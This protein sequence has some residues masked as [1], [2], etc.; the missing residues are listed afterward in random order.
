[1]PCSG[2]ASPPPC[3]TM[4]PLPSAQEDGEVLPLYQ[5]VS[6]SLAPRLVAVPPNLLS[7]KQVCCC[8]P[9]ARVRAWPAYGTAVA[10]RHTVLPV[11][12]AHDPRMITSSVSFLARHCWVLQAHDAR[13]AL[14]SC[15]LP[16]RAAP[17]AAVQTEAMSDLHVLHACRAPPPGMGPAAASCRPT[18]PPLALPLAAGAQPH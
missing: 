11:A 16:G 17:L 3:N 10:G 1:M 2:P 5:A 9:P 18:H 15:S 13:P 14:A 6:P 7:I 4:S 12:Q 8:P